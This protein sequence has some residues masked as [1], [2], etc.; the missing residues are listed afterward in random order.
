MVN[1]WQTSFKS[2]LGKGLFNTCLWSVCGKGLILSPWK[3][4]TGEK[5]DRY[6]GTYLCT[7]KHV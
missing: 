2:V 1:V 7:K 3:K 6:I 5:T 4:L